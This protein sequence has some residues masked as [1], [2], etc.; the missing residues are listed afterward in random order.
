LP[1]A[2]NASD[3]H[4]TPTF[5]QRSS[6][7]LL[8]L[9]WD[10]SAG[11][12]VYFL[13]FSRVLIRM[14]AKD[15]YGSQGEDYLTS[16][17][18][19]FARLEHERKDAEY[20]RQLAAEAEGD[21]GYH[22]GD[23][24]ESEHAAQ[25]AGYHGLPA[26]RKP[27]RLQMPLVQT[28]MCC[29]SLRCGVLIIAACD[30]C[31]SIFQTLAA[32]IVLL[33]P[34][35]ALEAKDETLFLGADMEARATRFLVREMRMRLF[36]ALATT[37]Y[38]VRGFRAVQAVDAQGLREYLNWK[39]LDA[40]VFAFMGVALHRLWWDGCGYLP[41]DS[42][43]DLRYTYVTNTAISL[44]MPIYCIW[45]V[46]SLYHVL[47]HG[48]SSTL[49]YAGFRPHSVVPPFSHISG[50]RRRG[51]ASPEVPVLRFLRLYKVPNFW[52]R[53]AASGFS[54]R[55]QRRDSSP[56]AAA[57]PTPPFSLLMSLDLLA[58][59]RPPPRAQ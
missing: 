26:G 54:L 41:V 2:T 6:R 21:D 39:V 43:W 59:R 20:A 30:A 17:Q 9:F 5:R 38:A 49:V 33:L 40:A 27:S 28:F 19:E 4:V 25:R 13:L 34:Q 55:V 16:E 44:L 52:W 56:F 1:I 45:I 29:I 32:L 50:A 3:L 15:L 36:L 35:L 51:R 18:R 46:W 14:S 7:L 23:G 10:A 48:D 57:R 58:P 22:M 12:G 24:G 53:A 37:C 8:N 47:E 11:C 42:C 31:A